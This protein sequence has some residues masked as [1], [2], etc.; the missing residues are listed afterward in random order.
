MAIF[1]SYVC[2]AKGKWQPWLP[3]IKWLTAMSRSQHVRIQTCRCWLSIGNQETRTCQP[4]KKM[5]QFNKGNGAAFSF[6]VQIPLDLFQGPGYGWWGYGGPKPSMGW[7]KGDPG[8]K[9]HWFDRI[10]IMSPKKMG[11][12]GENPIFRQAQVTYIPQHVPIKSHEIKWQFITLT[13]INIDPP[14]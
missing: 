13:Q 7:F 14:K 1:N 3:K 2:L 6:R 8:W 11:H 9:L 4:R 5:E 12:R 10:I